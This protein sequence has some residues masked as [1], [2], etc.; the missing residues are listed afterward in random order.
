MAITDGIKAWWN[1]NVPDG[2]DSSGNLQTLTGTGNAYIANATGLIGKGITVNATSNGT[3]SGSSVLSF[4]TG[5]F[6]MSM[7]VNLTGLGAGVVEGLV[8]KGTNPSD[9]EY[10]FWHGANISVRFYTGTT[11]HYIGAVTID[12]PLG[13]TAA[14]VWKHIVITK[15]GDTNMNNIK[16]YVDS[17]LQNVTP[18]SLGTY[19][20]MTT[21][22]GLFNLGML[23]TPA[24]QRSNGIYDLV[25]LWNRELSQLEID[26]LYNNRNG[27]DIFPPPLYNPKAGAMFQFF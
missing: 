22:T 11:S 26:A 9:R 14:G 17:V 20:G 16:I 10:Q 21:S 23:V 3:I 2:T 12:S 8:V 27:L 15:P 13:A 1:F 24:T 7:F 25:G 5:A 19:A 18:N 6:S 4:G